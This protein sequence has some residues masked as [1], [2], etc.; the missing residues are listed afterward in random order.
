MTDDYLG[1]IFVEN[2]YHQIS[3]GHYLRLLRKILHLE[4]PDFYREYF[5]DLLITWELRDFGLAGT[6]QLE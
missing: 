4:F 6:S 5:C 2:V 3:T 1:T